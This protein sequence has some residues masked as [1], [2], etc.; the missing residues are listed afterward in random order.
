MWILQLYT[1]LGHLLL[2]SVSQPIRAQYP[3]PVYKA[4]APQPCIMQSSSGMRGTISVEV[5]SPLFASTSAAEVHSQQSR[6]QGG[7]QCNHKVA[8]GKNCTAV[9]MHQYAA[10]SLSS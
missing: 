5:S 8:N 4:A 1:L 10:L 6:W 2:S 9:H 3:T 7:Q